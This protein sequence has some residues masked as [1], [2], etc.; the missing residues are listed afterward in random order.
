M[1]FVSIKISEQMDLLA[2]HRACYVNQR[3]GVINQ[4]RGFL[5]ERIITFRSMLSGRLMIPQRYSKKKMV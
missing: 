1:H 5:I 3:I 2:L 4:N